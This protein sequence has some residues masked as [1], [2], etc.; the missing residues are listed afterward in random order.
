MDTGFTNPESTSESDRLS[1]YDGRVAQMDALTGK[2]N[3][4]RRQPISEQIPA[5]GEDV[6]IGCI[7]CARA[8]FST[9]AGT[10][11]EAIRFA[12]ED[13]LTHPEVQ[14][15]L[16]AAEEEV[17]NVERHDW[18]PEKTLNSPPREKHVIHGFFPGLRRLRQ[19]IMQITTVD[20]LEHAAANAAHLSTDFRLA[21]LEMRGVNT[22]G[23]KDAA[24]KPGA[25]RIIAREAGCDSAGKRES[26]GSP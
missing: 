7:A 25:G 5:A 15:R 21:V 19:Q 8:H 6:S 24:S 20:D 26:K 12:R 22:G 16:Q 23:V 10:L 2:D 17:T 9:I 14:S 18:T 1:Q 3:A 13:G 4:L 11:K